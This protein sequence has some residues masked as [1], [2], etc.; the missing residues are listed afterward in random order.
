MEFETFK[1]KACR[2]GESQMLPGHL[3]VLVT[4]RCPVNCSHC[5]LESRPDSGSDLD[6]DKFVAWVEH[7]SPEIPIKSVCLTG[8]EPFF[9]YDLLIELCRRLS[10]LDLVVGVLTSAYWAVSDAK[11]KELL[12]T[13]ADAGLSA[14]SVSVD[15]HHL[16]HIPAT[17]LIR[18]LTEAKKLKLITSVSLRYPASMDLSQAY[19]YAMEVLGEAVMD[20]VD[21]FSCGKIQSVGRARHLTDS[22]SIE[23]KGLIAPLRLCPAYALS[24]HPPNRIQSCCG[25]RLPESAP[26]FLGTLETITLVDSFDI[27]R[28]SLTGL[29]LQT[30]GLSEILDLAKT[31]GLDEDMPEIRNLDNICGICLEIQGRPSIMNFLLDRYGNAEGIRT[32]ALKRFFTTGESWRYL[33]RERIRLR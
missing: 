7:A 5:I 6:I 8:G 31:V 23:N 20:G 13:L 25:L 10:S 3:G 22:N 19:F 14:F 33:N 1:N 16:S 12:A 15:E 17:N 9:L 24:I 30:V 11:T 18:A 21:S 2:N 29:I 4:D 32:L 26:L 28:T 27:W